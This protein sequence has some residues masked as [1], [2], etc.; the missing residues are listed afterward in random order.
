MRC[1]APEKTGSTGGRGSDGDRGG[2]EERTS[3]ALTPR[4]TNYLRPC[5]SRGQENTLNPRFSWQ[6]PQ[7]WIRE[8]CGEAGRGGEVKI[9]VRCGIGSETRRCFVCS[10]TGRYFGFALG[11]K[12]VKVKRSRSGPRAFTCRLHLFIIRTN[13]FFFLLFWQMRMRRTKCK[14]C[15]CFFIWTKAN[16]CELF[17]DDKNGNGWQAH[18]A[19]CDW[20]NLSAHIRSIS[21]FIVFNRALSSHLC[22]FYWN[23][24][25]S[26]LLNWL[27]YLLF[28][29]YSVSVFPLVAFLWLLLFWSLLNLNSALSFGFV[30][31]FVFFNL[32][33][34]VHMFGPSWKWDGASQ[35]VGRG[36]FQTARQ[37][38]L[39][40]QSWWR[41]PQLKELHLSRG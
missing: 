36:N 34:F 11:G 41:R 12:N 24:S 4:V 28:T 9:K 33:L 26:G 32:L 27:Y 21:S 30:C 17:A 29:V 19:H 8:D 39:Y 20:K 23:Y 3:A 13:S 2:N 22:L 6:W 31:L 10:V 37:T 16:N 25:N 35:R 14:A 1:L 7:D 40:G 38:K 18:C 15:L 5:T